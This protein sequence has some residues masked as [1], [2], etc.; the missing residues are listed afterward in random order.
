MGTGQER[1]PA[2][3]CCAVSC[4][5]TVLGGLGKEPVCLTGDENLCAASAKAFHLVFLKGGTGHKVHAVL[6]KVLHP[7]EGALEDECAVTGHV[8][9]QE[10][11]VHFVVLGDNVVL[12]EQAMTDI[13][14]VHGNVIVPY[15][16]LDGSDIHKDVSNPAVTL[17][18]RMGIVHHGV[19]MGDVLEVC[20]SCEF[21]A[22]VL[23]KM[24]V[25]T[26]GIDHGIPGRH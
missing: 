7:G 14:E 19:R 5:I 16:A 24:V 3:A 4:G 20:G 11:L 9:L 18:H 15:K 12:L 22:E 21:T 23:S 2:V 25:G 26:L 10:V 13:A 6:T 1:L 8:L 17:V